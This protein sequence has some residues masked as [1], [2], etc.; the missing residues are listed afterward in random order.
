MSKFRDTMIRS[1]NKMLRINDTII[2]KAMINFIEVDE[3]KNTIY[4]YLNNN[5]IIRIKTNDYKIIK[6][7]INKVLE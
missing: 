1:Y 7:I 3:I 2:N 4:L 5:S 6:E